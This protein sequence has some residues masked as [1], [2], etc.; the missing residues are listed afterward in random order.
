MTRTSLP[1]VAALAL[2]AAAASAPALAQ[3]DDFD[4][5]TNPNGWTFGVTTGD[6]L[7]PTGGNPDGWLR[8]P[9]IDSFAPILTSGSTATNAL[10]ADMRA[11]GVTRIDVDAITNDVSITAG[12]RNFTILLRDTK[13]TPS[14]D[15]D[16]YAY[17]VGALVPQVGQGWVSY[18][19]DV[20]SASTDPTPA[21]WSGGWVGDLSAFRP[22][23]TWSD[24]ITSVDV[25]EF[26]W[27]D[28]T[29]FA[30]LQQWDVGVDN[31]AIV[32]SDLGVN[33]CG[34]ANPN[35]TGASGEISAAGSA[36]VAANDVTLRATSLPA[37]QFG[38]FV[39]GQ[40]QGFTPNPGGSSGDLC[41]GGAIGRYNQP[42]QILVTN[43]AGEMTLALD[44]T[45]TPTPNALVAI[46]AG[47]TWSFQGWH[48]DIV[49]GL[50]TS[51]FTDGLEITFQ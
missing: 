25:V 28:P 22:G 15:D 12:G 8:N 19:F 2:G 3:T 10:P 45:E 49:A 14:V 4:A 41:L 37:N 51:N 27:I 33:Y 43:A 31:I 44:L 35:S 48:R 34:P 17:S 6:V 46:A 38:I 5:G 1:H 42:G 36:D 11:A 26:W 18:S 21:G 40:T 23:V 47:E 9:L 32:S 50:P 30:I 39:V 13:G 29:F 16:D 20:P 7:E 24:L